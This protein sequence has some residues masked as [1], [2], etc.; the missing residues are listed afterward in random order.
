VQFRLLCTIETTYGGSLS[1]LSSLSVVSLKTVEGGFCF[2]EGVAQRTGR[3]FC[4]GEA[5]PERK[6]CVVSLDQKAAEDLA[7]MA[8][9]SQDTLE[10]AREHGQRR[11]ISLLEGVRVEVKLEDALLALPLGEHPS[12]SE[13]GISSGKG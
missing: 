7:K 8:L 3:L 12:G 5:Q 13:R 11:L 10:Y 4:Y 9:W 6:G 1:E 2:G